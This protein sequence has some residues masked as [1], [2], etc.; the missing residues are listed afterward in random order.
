MVDVPVDH[1]KYKTD[2]RTIRV[3][4]ADGDGMAPVTIKEVLDNS[5]L[6]R[7]TQAWRWTNLILV[8]SNYA[9]LHVINWAAE[10]GERLTYWVF[11][12]ALAASIAFHAY[13]RHKHPSLPGL[14]RAARNS[15]LTEEILLTWDRVSALA[16]LIVV[17]QSC[18]VT[19][20]LSSPLGLMALF[21]NGLSELHYV[22]I[23]PWPWWDRWVYP[24]AHSM[25]HYLVF[26]AA[27]VHILRCNGMPVM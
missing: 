9:A 26:A 21:F 27:Y 3:Y 25:W 16:C 8:I 20:L 2:K 5:M 6:W 19:P 15:V 7:P 4:D 13:E 1:T 23:V 24:W 11:L 22:G 17:L 18:G 14:V 10:N 12:N